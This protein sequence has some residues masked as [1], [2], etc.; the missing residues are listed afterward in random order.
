MNVLAD[1]YP[2][3]DVWGARRRCDFFEWV[4]GIPLRVEWREP[5]NA[6][7]IPIAD[8][9]V[10]PAVAKSENGSANGQ[11]ERVVVGTS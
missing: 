8:S 4:F 6:S 7:D 3:V 10:E 1:E 11:P 5:K 9:K 2:E